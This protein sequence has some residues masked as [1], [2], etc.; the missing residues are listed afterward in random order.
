MSDNNP[1]GYDSLKLRAIFIPEGNPENITAADITDHLGHDSLRLRAVLIPDGN[2]D[3]V[4]AA[5]ITD[6]LGHDVVRVGYSWSDSGED[7]QE[8]EPPV[9][10]ADGGGGAAGPVQGAD[11]PDVAP[12]GRSAAS[13]M[14]PTPTLAQAARYVDPAKTAVATWRATNALSP[15]SQ[16]A[17]SRGADGRGG[18]VA[19][20]ESGSADTPGSSNL[21]AYVSNDP[22]NAT[23]PSRLFANVGAEVTAG[24]QGKGGSGSIVQVSASVPDPSGE[25][26]PNL[27]SPQTQQQQEPQPESPLAPTVDP[28][29]GARRPGVS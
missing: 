8:Q 3:N 4:S 17:A 28:R 29:T 20:P 12:T 25:I 13:A 9:E 7:Q 15:P 22:L 6:W 14:P 23:D 10:G 2:P 27:N 26:E 21:Y 1:F 24:L 19:R 11:G 18:T 16:P 5:D